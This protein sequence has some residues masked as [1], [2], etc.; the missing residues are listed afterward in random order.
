[1]RLP[2]K[3]DTGTTWYH[4]ILYYN[5]VLSWPLRTYLADLYEQTQTRLDTIIFYLK[6][7]ESITEKFKVRDQLAWVAADE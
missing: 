7:A 5:M 4:P 1:M 6:L 3:L 2:F